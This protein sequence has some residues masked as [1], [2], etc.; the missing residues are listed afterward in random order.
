[1]ISGD[2]GDS[3]L[4]KSYGQPFYGDE[5]PDGGGGAGVEGGG[6]GLE[7]ADWKEEGDIKFLVFWMKLW[8]D[9]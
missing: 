3:D 6:E 1:M 2:A 8:I 7:D 4:Y 9:R 5:D